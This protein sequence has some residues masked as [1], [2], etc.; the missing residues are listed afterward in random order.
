MSGEVAGK[1]AV[2]PGVGFG[3]GK[4]LVK[5]HGDRTCEGVAESWYGQA[6]G[7]QPC[8]DSLNP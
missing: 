3:L 2:I 6:A 5:G 4:P 1:I 8:P 7:C